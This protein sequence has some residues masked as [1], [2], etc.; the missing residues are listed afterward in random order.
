MLPTGG[1]CQRRRDLKVQAQSQNDGPKG[2]GPVVHDPGEVPIDASL[3][4]LSGP[5][6]WN[7]QHFQGRVAWQSRS[8]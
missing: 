5:S 7:C 8:A 6:F 3:G 1:P 4:I 2:G